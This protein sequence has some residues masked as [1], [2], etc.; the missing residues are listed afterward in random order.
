[1]TED[2]MNKS[3]AG[4]LKKV[5]KESGFTSGIYRFLVKTKRKIFYFIMLIIYGKGIS[6]RAKKRWDESDPDKHLTWGQEISGDHFIR[7]VALYQVFS[8]NKAVLEI[9]PGYGRLIKSCLKNK[10]PFSR[11]T[12]I[13]ISQKNIEYLKQQ[14][15]NSNIKFVQGDIESVSLSDKYDIVISSLTL[16]HIFPSFEKALKNIVGYLNKNARLF[17][18]LIEGDEAYF[19][20]SVTYIRCYTKNEV[21]KILKNLSLQ[22]V[23]FD[24]VIHKE[25]YIRLLVI[26]KKI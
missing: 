25:N 24:Y 19:E 23:A 10:I 4:N 3:K 17:F 22:L 26:A 1:M 2:K 20:S 12:G 6:T 18:D 8:K 15:S 11:F 5:L 9:G 21:Q 16:K 7:K 13:D 14:Y